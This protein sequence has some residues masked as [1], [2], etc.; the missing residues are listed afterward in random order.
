MLHSSLETGPNGRKVNIVQMVFANVAQALKVAGWMNL[1]GTGKPA[2]DI[3]PPGVRKTQTSETQLR[4]FRTYFDMGTG[5][6]DTGVRELVSLSEGQGTVMEGWKSASRAVQ[7][8]IARSLSGDEGA[9]F[10]VAGGK[11]MRSGM[12]EEERDKF[13]S[14]WLGWRRTTPC[15]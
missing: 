13:I 10:M 7:D 1:L 14:A 12:T 8:A 4:V 6:L 3:W 5:D 9:R 15:N 2:L 11:D